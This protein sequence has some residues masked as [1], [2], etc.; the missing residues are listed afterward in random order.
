M[1]LRSDEMKKLCV[2]ENKKGEVVRQIFLEADEAELIFLADLRRV[3][4]VSDLTS[5]D[6]AK[7]AYTKI[8][9]I[10]VAQLNKKVAVGDL[11]FLRL[12]SPEDNLSSSMVLPQ[13]DQTQIVESLKWTSS[14]AAC[15][16]LVLLTGLF[17]SKPPV[18]LPQEIVIVPKQEQ[19]VEAKIQPIAKEKK[20][21]IAP[22]KN[23]TK[24]IE[25]K[26]AKNVVK[27][28]VKKVQKIVKKSPV[29]VIKSR[30]HNIAKAKQPALNSMGALAVLGSMKN[31]KDVGGV[32]VSSHKT[33]RGAGLGGSGGS[34][35]MQTSFYGKGLTSA[36]L[37][38]GTRAEGGGGY[39]KHGK[40]GGQA[41]YGKMTLVGSSG[42]YFEP[43]VSE[44]EVEGGLDQSEIDQVIQ[45][46]QGQLRFCYEQ[47][48]QAQAKLSGRLTV[49]FIIG[50]Y[51]NVNEAGISG[52][53]M[54]SSPVE[55]CVLAKLKSWK[56]PTPRN[57]VLVKV[58]YPFNFKRMNNT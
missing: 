23:K 29:N 56:F 35:G 3:E 9:H 38:P 30:N 12:A 15:I 24:H 46:H 43:V 4:L 33:T 20:I 49:R 51:G 5:L 32:K 18:V 47:G 13:D 25:Q 42:G 2:L 6:E 26:I 31:S 37:G 27:K 44:V 21:A 28:A 16:L 48:L 11:G 55:A 22:N 14:F 8:A 10:S 39:G 7:V 53:S 45:R 52:T 19:K 41:G 57:G 1:A 17:F 40:G 58:N 50:G 54:H 36:P 34:G